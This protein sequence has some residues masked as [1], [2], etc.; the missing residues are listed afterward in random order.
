MKRPLDQC[1]EM[2]ASFQ[3]VLPL[4][5]EAWQHDFW[6]SIKDENLQIDWTAFF[7]SG[8]LHWSSDQKSSQIIARFSSFHLID[9][10]DD[11]LD[12]S[13]ESLS[14]DVL[15]ALGEYQAL[16][17]NFLASYRSIFERSPKLKSD[18]DQLAL[19]YHLSRLRLL[20]CSTSSTFHKGMCQSFLFPAWYNLG[21]FDGTPQFLFRQ[22]QKVNCFKTKKHKEMQEIRREFFERSRRERVISDEAYWQE[23]FAATEF[24]RSVIVDKM[25]LKG[26]SNQDSS[27]DPMG[28]PLPCYGEEHR[29]HLKN[30]GDLVAKLHLSLAQKNTPQIGREED[31]Q[32]IR[33]FNLFQAFVLN[34]FSRNGA[35]DL[36]WETIRDCFEQ[37][38][39]K[40]R[41]L[42]LLHCNL[43]TVTKKGA[44]MNLH[45]SDDYVCDEVCRRTLGNP[46]SSITKGSRW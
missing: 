13:I 1:F 8:G 26:L 30:I 5:E 41:F 33:S 21:Q 45:F 15:E 3:E 34:H 10:E 20:P 6:L 17:R 31:S 46:W 14:E 4:L 42:M 28:I 37:L 38:L 36:D 35:N 32:L 12:E 23:L 27:Y 7:E 39:Q 43:L 11:K 22:D 19:T 18:P 2:N 25:D 44:K 16:E 9:D 24:H 29:V 40:S